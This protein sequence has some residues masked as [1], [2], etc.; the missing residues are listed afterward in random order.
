MKAHMEEASEYVKGL[1]GR[2]DGRLIL[3]T[4]AA[5]VLTDS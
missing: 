4:R 1:Q 2:L 3:D 5:S